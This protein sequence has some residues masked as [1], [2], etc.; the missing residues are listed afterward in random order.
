MTKVTVEIEDVI[1]QFQS[2]GDEIRRLRAALRSAVDDLEFWGS[3]A[4]D[5]VKDKHDFADCVRNARA[6][7]DGDDCS[8]KSNFVEQP[9]TAFEG[10]VC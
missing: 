9:R 10:D 5:Y 6:A 4:S 3:Y 8:T 1:G 7:L 2:L